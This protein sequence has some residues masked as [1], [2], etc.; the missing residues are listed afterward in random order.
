MSSSVSM[1]SGGRDVLF[2]RTLGGLPVPL[3]TALRVSGLDDAGTLLNYPVDLE[4][5][6]ERGVPS[7][8]TSTAHSSI[9]SSATSSA[10]LQDR[11]GETG[12]SLSDRVVGACEVDMG[13]DPRT[14]QFVPSGGEVKT[15]H[16]NAGGDPKTDHS[17]FSVQTAGVSTENADS[18]HSG[19]L[20]TQT[21]YSATVSPALDPDFGLALGSEVRDELPS[22][23]EKP[24]HFDEMASDP[25]HFDGFPSSADHPEVRDGF[26]STHYLDFTQSAKRTGFT[27]IFRISENSERLRESD[28]GVQI[29]P[30][31]RS[32]SELS[33]HQMGL[34]L[35]GTTRLKKESIHSMF[36]SSPLAIEEW[37]QLSISDRALLR[38]YGS[39]DQ[40]RESTR[41]PDTH[42]ETIAVVQ[43]VDG[44][45]PQPLMSLHDRM[46]LRRYSVPGNESMPSY[47][48]SLSSIPPISPPVESA[49][50]R[51]RFFKKGK[52]SKEVK[53]EAFGNESCQVQ[54]G[55]PCGFSSQV[56][57]PPVRAGTTISHAVLSPAFSHFT[58]LYHTLVRDEPCL[59]VTCKNLYHWKHLHA[60]R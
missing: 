26:P 36:G 37:E 35:A 27:P 38:K 14:V 33:A 39:S 4:D 17:Y 42:E 45:P 23:Q 54:E 3:L 31:S 22:C 24:V 60:K 16:L 6:G 51:R 2:L 48:S 15:D 41:Q 10:G 29:V 50:K 47:C 12:W 1:T 32:P 7:G 49:K 18:P 13:G 56:A 58:L 43:R 25:V 34:S 53:K 5:E 59:R 9:L 44:H 8:A 30:A 11:A 52:L 20:A 57:E 55:S 19:G 28:P 40:P 21:A 46:L